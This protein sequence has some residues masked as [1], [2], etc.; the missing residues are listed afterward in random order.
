[1]DED[2][3]SEL[4]S[5][6]ELVSFSVSGLPCII[7]SMSSCM[8][9]VVGVDCE[10]CTSFES[11]LGVLD[12]ISVILRI[13]VLS[14]CMS[15]SYEESSELEDSSEKYLESSSALSMSGGIVLSS[16]DCEAESED[17]V[18]RVES[19]STSLTVS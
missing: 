6:S 13:G 18:S 16:D 7:L 10:D 11:E 5:S 2:D 3:S 4:E 19:D 1:M 8:D 15:S 9:S 12:R 17:S 14:D